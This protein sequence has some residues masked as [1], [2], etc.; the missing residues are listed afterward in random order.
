MGDKTTKIRINSGLKGGSTPIRING[1][2]IADIPHDTDFPASEAVLGVLTNSNIEF[3]VVDGGASGAPGTTG[4]AARGF[5]ASPAVV[6]HPE[7]KE[8]RELAQGDDAH[9]GPTAEQ[10]ASETIAP[11]RQARPQGPC[12]QRQAGPPAQGGEGQGRRRGQEA[13]PQGRCR[14]ACVLTPKEQPYDRTAEEADRRRQSAGASRVRR[15][16]SPAFRS[17]RGPA[18]ST[19]AR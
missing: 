8:P 18:R 6:S 11:G 12:A 2:E 1:Q 9:F 14:Q 5:A 10:K 16:G 13:R 15:A 19:S 17:I 4:E 3:T 7:P